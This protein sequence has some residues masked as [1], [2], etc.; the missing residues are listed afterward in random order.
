MPCSII[1]KANELKKKTLLNLLLIQ[2]HCNNLP[3]SKRSQHHSV[4]SQTRISL[5]SFN[6]FKV[7]STLQN[8]ASDRS[9]NNYPYKPYAHFL[10][11]K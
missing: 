10:K 8:L 4:L 9:C 7:S 1:N 11:G 6:C 5:A 3:V 2:S